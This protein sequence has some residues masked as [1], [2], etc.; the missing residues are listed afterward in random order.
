MRTVAFVLFDDVVGLDVTGPAEV[1]DMANRLHQGGPQP[2][3]LEILALTGGPV[4]TASGVGIQAQDAS[5]WVGPID[6]LIV[7]G[8]YG[9]GQRGP[10]DALVLWVKRAA[11]RS[12]RVCSVCTGAYVLAAAGLLDGRRA[13]TH[14]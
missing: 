8:G 4:R 6:T 2:Y 1:F 13:V 10:A 12:R 9:V 3:H 14:W 7:P 5:Q 11:E